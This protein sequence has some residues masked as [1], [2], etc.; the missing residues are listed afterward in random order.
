MNRELIADGENGFLAGSTEEWVRALDR[1][2]ADPAL[3]SG[4][5]AEG[6][7]TV[8]RDYS[9]DVASRKLIAVFDRLV[10][11]IRI[12]GGEPRLR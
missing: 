9:L 7:R 12:P 2:L 6:R 8:L 1:L 11:G 4:V 3:A 10:G 5:G